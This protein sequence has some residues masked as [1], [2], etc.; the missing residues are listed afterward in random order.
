MTVDEDRQRPDLSA[1][2]IHREEHD[3]RGVS[4]GTI[5]GWIVA[6][7]VALGAAIAIYKV[8]I[9][10]RRAPVVYALPTRRRR[11]PAQ[12]GESESRADPYQHAGH[13]RS[14]A[15]RRDNCYE[16][17]RGGRSHLLGDDGPGRRH[18]AGRRDLHPRRSEDARSRRRRQ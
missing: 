7:A 11:G 2:R 15:V 1:L 10:P 18:A 14:R 8:W 13:G 5:V 9:V 6:I 17:Y 16:E 12:R 4:W 3:A